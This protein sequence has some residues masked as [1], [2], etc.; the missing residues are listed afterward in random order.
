M[1][2]IFMLLLTVSMLFCLIACSKDNVSNS[3]ETSTDIQQ[4]E[5]NYVSESDT[6]VSSA[7]TVTVNTEAVISTP[8]ISEQET[9]EQKEIIP[10]PVF[11]TDNITRIAFSIN[12][13]YGDEC[14]VPQQYMTEIVNWLGT[15]TVGEKISEDIPIAPGTG[16][17]Y[18]H[19]V[20]SDGT[21]VK[22]N[23]STIN[24]DGTS[25]Y[26]SSAETPECFMEILS[27]NN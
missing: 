17:Y 13:G 4:T 11:R 7:P 15:F 14:E 18:V 9:S 8:E 22:N 20:Y 23:L 6:A 16:F 1:N 25:Y 5:T 27:Q 19:I 12:Y 10:E 2:K 21:E 24:I 26:M 3:D